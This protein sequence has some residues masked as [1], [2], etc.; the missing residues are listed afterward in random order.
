MSSKFPKGEWLSAL[1][2]LEMAYLL[3]VVSKEIF[4]FLSLSE[5]LRVRFTCKMCKWSRL[6]ILIKAINSKIYH[7]NKSCCFSSP[8]VAKDEMLRLKAHGDDH[9]QILP[10]NGALP[11]SSDSLKFRGSTCRASTMKPP[12]SLGVHHLTEGAGEQVGI[13]EGTI[14]D[15]ES[16]HLREPPHLQDL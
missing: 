3:V 8:I 5:E 7:F 11:K 15:I 2:E 14:K 4:G 13:N 10:W 1:A 16:E 6:S 9:R 12:I